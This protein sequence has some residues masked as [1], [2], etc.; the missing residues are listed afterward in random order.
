MFREGYSSH[1]SYKFKMWKH[2]WVPLE[3]TDEEKMHL[4]TWM[5]SAIQD[6]EHWFVHFLAERGE[7]EEEEGNEGLQRELKELLAETDPPAGNQ[8]THAKLQ[9][10]LSKMHDILKQTNPRGSE[11]QRLIDESEL[12]DS[13]AVEKKVVFDQNK[14]WDEKYSLSDLFWTH[15]PR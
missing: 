14:F 10:C 9:Q 15:H 2:S 5:D 6:L 12:N 7:E 4:R 8:E 1:L 11:L 3:T 13:E